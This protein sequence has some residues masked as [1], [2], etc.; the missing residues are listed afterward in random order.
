MRPE[1]ML[2][3][4]ITFGQGH[5]GSPEGKEQ[6]SWMSLPPRRPQTLEV[7]LAFFTGINCRS[8]CCRCYCPPPLVRLLGPLIHFEFLFFLFFSFFFFGWHK[9][10][11]MF[12]CR[13]SLASL[14]FSTLGRR[15]KFSIQFTQFTAC[16]FQLPV[17]CFECAGKFKVGKYENNLNAFKKEFC[18]KVS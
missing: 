13:L 10:H 5:S 9:T 17:G 4:Q 11:C 8:C 14:S 2:S 12:A 1:K 18:E 3:T 16:F 15:R 7:R 6:G